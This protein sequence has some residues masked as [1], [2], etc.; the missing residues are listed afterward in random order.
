LSPLIPDW[1]QST[2]HAH[3]D[4]NS[5]IIYSRGQYLTG[6]TGYTGVKLSADH[7]TI[8]VDG[9]G[10]ENDGRHEVFKEVPLERLNKLRLA[11]YW[12][13]SEFFYARGEAAPAYFS[14]LGVSRFDRNFLYVS[15]DYFVIWDQ[16]ATAEPRA[17]SWLLNADQ[18]FRAQNN[19]SF[20]VTIKDVTLFVNRLMPASVDQQIERQ[21]VTTQG[22]PG[23]V[24]KGKLEERGFQLVES[25][26]VRRREIQFLHF[27]RAAESTERNPHLSGLPG[28]AGALRIQWPNGDE[29]TVLVRDQS[30]D[31]RI[32]GE[33]AVVRVSRQGVL[34]RLVLQRGTQIERNGVQ[35]FHSLRSVSASLAKSEAHEWRG[36]V[37]ADMATTIVVSSPVAWSNLRINGLT[38]RSE[39]DALKKTVTFNVPAGTN[40]IEA[41]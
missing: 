41:N 36:T 25:T 18:K 30:N 34:Q 23:E 38:S 6:D 39:Y 35:L 16:L 5:F 1:R 2:G 8:L 26:N 28:V 3:P 40:V 37:I 10:Q 13:T 22:R 7:N 32:R 24:E 29:E 11:D 19:N 12:A 20:A 4:A 33:R 27:L 21:V 15:P 9:R 31:V 14:D 17:F